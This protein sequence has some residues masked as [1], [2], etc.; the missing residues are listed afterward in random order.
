MTR[1]TAD[2]IHDL[3]KTAADHDQSGFM[4]QTG[5]VVGFE[6]ECRI[7]FRGQPDRLAT[8]NT[9]VLDGGI[10]LGFIKVTRMGKDV[11]FLSKPL[12]EFQNNPETQ[13]IL[14]ALCNGLGKT[15]AFDNRHT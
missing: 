8:L 12:I 3:D 11:E 2:V 9:M 13:K 4:T 15:L 1:T 10:P 5:L 6:H 14:T 7:V